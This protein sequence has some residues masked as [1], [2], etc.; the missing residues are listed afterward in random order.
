MASGTCDVLHTS[1]NLS[2][3][4]VQILWSFFG[5]FQ[6]PL[7]TPSRLGKYAYEDCLFYF[8]VQFDSDR[9]RHRTVRVPTSKP[10]DATK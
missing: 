7:I 3:L 4:I 5:A 1:G 9:D 8:P 6:F 10:K 2:L